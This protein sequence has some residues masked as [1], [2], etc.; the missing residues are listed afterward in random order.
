MKTT[1]IVKIEG[2][3]LPPIESLQID[4]N[5]IWSKTTGRGADGKMIG[6]RVAFKWKLNISF[7]PLSDEQQAF[8]L[9][10]IENQAFF[11]VTFRS[12]KTGS[13]ITI[14]A[15]AGDFKSPVYSYVDDLPRYVGAAVNLVEQ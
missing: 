9:N 11:N 7:A 1:K 14:K 5:C 6:D 12:P 8:L 2:Q 15:Y 13:N 3:N 4:R 10:L